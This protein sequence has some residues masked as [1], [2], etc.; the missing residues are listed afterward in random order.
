MASEINLTQGVP[1]DHG[2]AKS[3]HFPSLCTV[4]LTS[5]QTC[6][7]HSHMHALLNPPEPRKHISR[8]DKMCREPT[9]MHD[10]ILLWALS[11]FHPH[12]SCL[13]PPQMSTYHR[14]KEDN[15]MPVKTALWSVH[16]RARTSSAAQR[17]CARPQS[18]RGGGRSRRGSRPRLGWGSRSR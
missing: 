8:C 5:M 11:S 6:R 12:N 9:P 3:S 2:H 4:W 7:V 13:C 14:P 16:S 18:A 1:Q 10:S 17:R 15:G